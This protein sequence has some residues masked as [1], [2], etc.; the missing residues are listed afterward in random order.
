M[1]TLL[2]LLP[3]LNS[4][5][6]IFAYFYSLYFT[7]YMIDYFD[8]TVTAIVYLC[9]IAKLLYYY[10]SMLLQ[11]SPTLSKNGLLLIVNIRF[12]LP[13]NMEQQIYEVAVLG[14]GVIGSATAYYLASSGTR[15]VLLLEQVEIRKKLIIPKHCNNNNKLIIPSI[16]TYTTT[17]NLIMQD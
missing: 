11:Y 1:L 6:A 5:L 13:K 2:L 14:A 9:R 3:L 7:V 4:S 16:Q 12:L 8:K 10:N 15:P 17:L